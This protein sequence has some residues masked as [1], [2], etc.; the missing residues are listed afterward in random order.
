MLASLGICLL[1]AR[2]ARISI[3]DGV[4]LDLDGRGR[5]RRVLP[6]GPRSRLRRPDAD[7]SQADRTANAAFGPSPAEVAWARRIIE[8]Y[9]AARAAGK[10]V[11][12]VD[13]KL[14]ENLHVLEA[15]RLVALAEMIAERTSLSAPPLSRRAGAPQ[16]GLSAAAGRTEQAV[17]PQRQHQRE[18]REHRHLAG[19][20]WAGSRPT[21][22][23]S[24]PI[25]TPPSAAPGTEPMPPTT[26]AVSA[27]KPHSA[28]MAK[29]TMP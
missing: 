28:P 4:H 6:P 5:L 15:R 17:R 29:L 13:G 19:R 20:R 8:A 12:V 7:P 23:S 2:A 18:Q 16:A 14:V 22:L 21:E 24:R 26:A 25:S 3:L 11:V 9:D 1:A 10:G 27:L